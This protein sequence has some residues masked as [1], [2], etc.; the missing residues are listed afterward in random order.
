MIGKPTTAR[1]AARSRTQAG[2]CRRG[3]WLLLLPLLCGGCLPLTIPPDPPSSTVSTVETVA[4]GRDVPRDCP[5][6]RQDGGRY[7]YKDCF[8]LYM[9]NAPAGKALL[10]LELP[11]AAHVPNRT[12][13]TGTLQ[14]PTSDI[15]VVGSLGSQTWLRLYPAAGYAEARIAADPETSW[16]HMRQLIGTICLSCLRKLETLGTDFDVILIDC[17]TMQFYPVRYPGGH[18]FQIRDWLFITRTQP[19]EDPEAAGETI[20]LQ[21]VRPAAD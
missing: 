9:T 3:V 5:I 17:K 13:A 15:R 19:P 20:T 7:V 12:Y 1:A 6:C 16:V 2:K 14:R 8:A 21:A 11:R 18:V 4:P 10:L